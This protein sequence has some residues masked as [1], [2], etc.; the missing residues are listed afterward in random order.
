MFFRS[1]TLLAMAAGV[2]I[3]IFSAEAQSPPT[4]VVPLVITASGAA[5]DAVILPVTVNTVTSARAVD[6]RAQWIGETLNQVPGVYDAALRG[7]V[8]APSI[9]M[10]LTYDNY[11]LYL[12]D[13]V[14]LQSSLSY[15]HSALAFSSALTSDGGMEILKGPG[16]ALYGSDAVAAV[17]NVTSREPTREASGRVRVGGGMFGAR[18]VRAEHSDRLTDEQ[19][20]RVA[21]AYEGDDGWRDNTGWERVQGLARHRY[22]TAATRV[23]TIVTATRFRTEMAGP[24]DRATF[25]NDPTSSGLQPGVDPAAAVETA[26]YARLS[27]AVQQRLGSGLSLEVTPYVRRID[28][29]YLEVWAP[30]TTPLDTSVTETLGALARL[31][32]RPWSG[33][34][35]ILGTDGESSRLAYTSEQTRPTVTGIYGALTSYQGVNYDYTV[36]YRNIAPYIQLQQMLGEHLL[37]SAGLRYDQARYDYRNHLGPTTDPDDFVYRPASRVDDFHQASPKLGVTYLLTDEQ[38][39]FGRYAHGFRLPTAASLYNLGH[40]QTAFTLTPERFDSYELG[41]KGR[42]EDLADW[43]LDG[44]WV[45][46][47]DGIVPG[48]STAAGEISA[49]GG[50]RRYRGLEAGGNLRPGGGIEL[51]ASYAHTFHRIVQWLSAGDDPRDGHIPQGAPENLANGRIAWRPEPLP[52]LRVEV[53]N[54]WLGQWWIDDEN[55]E[56]TP[57][58]V[59]WNVR[60]SYQL[61]RRWSIDGK[62]LNLFDRHY[63][64]T[65]ENSYGADNFRPGAPFTAAGGMEAT[66]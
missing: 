66:W 33:G 39:L 19:S 46:S 47:R 22:E 51:G 21:A 44:Y 20:G 54:Q 2:P 8:D 14:P 50:R 10:P 65:A 26:T 28:S 9:R 52:A 35:L 37:I 23:D 41:Y 61:S 56:Q 5:E 43:E 42:Q 40:G 60:A 1:S 12:Q 49:N 4:P 6:N 64:A 36:D 13:G 58:V 7:V 3:T 18:E 53:E 55:T 38:S 34:E 25:E 59:L 29:S 15:K 27:S 48:V 62:V 17:I 32:S 30:D 16:T 11:Y 57:N 63:A 45:E 31:R 24:L